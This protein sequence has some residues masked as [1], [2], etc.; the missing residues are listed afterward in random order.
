MLRFETPRLIGIAAT[1]ALARADAG[2]AAAFSRLLAARIPGSWP[3]EVM[4]DVREHFA[5]QLETGAMTPGWAMWYLLAPRAEPPRRLIGVVGFYGR[6]DAD[7]TATLGYGIAPEDEG[8]GFATEAVAGLMAWG[9]AHGGVAAF[10]A[11]TFELH[12]ASVRV[13]QKNGFACVGVSPDDAEAPDSDRQGRGRLMVWR[14]L[15]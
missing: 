5:H 8:Q 7:G 9:R 11:T 12:H 1:P 13:L 14:R 4:A 2:D 15:A 6:P 3:I 10:A